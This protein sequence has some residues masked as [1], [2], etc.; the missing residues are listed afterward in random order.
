[1]R[2]IS[3][4]FIKFYLNNQLDSN[5][6][7]NFAFTMALFVPSHFCDKSVIINKQLP[8]IQLKVILWDCLAIDINDF[9]RSKGIQVNV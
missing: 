9:V 2:L 1:M 5:L 8:E 4:H 7:P 3:W 6:V